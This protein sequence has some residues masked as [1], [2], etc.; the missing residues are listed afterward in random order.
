M[1][2][3]QV[4]YNKMFWLHIC[5]H[6]IHLG[7]LVS[8]RENHKNLRKSYSWCK[9]CVNSENVHPID[10][11]TQKLSYLRD[12]SGALH[13]TEQ[14]CPAGTCTINN[15]SRGKRLKCSES[16]WGCW[17][18]PAFKLCFVAAVLKTFA[19]AF[20]TD[21]RFVLICSCSISIGFGLLENFGLAQGIFNLFKGTFLRWPC[22]FIYF[23][24][25]LI[26]SFNCDFEVSTQY[27]FASDYNGRYLHARTFI[28]SL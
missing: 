3:T 19:T 26:N 16:N 20:I 5:T 11:C 25:N 21:E 17:S 1:Y 9:C 28:M 14:W 22:I 24:A 15:S 12:I 8:L 4:P 2:D 7:G 27:S 10:V 13:L 23:F 6:L 18:T